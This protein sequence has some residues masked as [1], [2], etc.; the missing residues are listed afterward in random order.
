M[1]IVIGYPFFLENRM[2]QK[3]FVVTGLELGWDNVIGIFSQD[4]VT[5]E[6]LEKSF[7][8]EEKYYISDMAV[9]INLSEYFF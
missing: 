5:K 4:H 6:D 7:P 8:K 9:E 1:G 2:K 3:V